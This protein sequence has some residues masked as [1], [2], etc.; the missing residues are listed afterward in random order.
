MRVLH[1]AARLLLARLTGTRIVWTAHDLESPS[2]RHPLLD[3]LLTLI[4]PRLAHRTIV[5][6]NTARTRLAAAARISDRNLHVIPHGHYIGYYPDSIPRNDA[7]AKLGIGDDEVVFLLFGWVKRYKH[8]V[9]LIRAF[10]SLSFA[11][12]RLVIA[13]KASDRTFEHE[14]R[15]EAAADPRILLH[16]RSIPDEDVQ[17]FMNASDVAVF[18]YAPVLTSGAIVLAQSFGKACVVASNSGVED[19]EDSNGAFFYDSLAEGGLTRAL[20]LAIDHRDRLPQ[21]GAYNRGNAARQ[22]WQDVAEWTLQLY[23]EIL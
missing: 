15:T 17:V 16:L 20:Q 12:A 9:E 11:D 14:I 8:I 4:L 22:S 7:R 3:R 6:S 23:T 21:S 19:T 1:F 5:H 10:Q 2:S 13:G 18:P